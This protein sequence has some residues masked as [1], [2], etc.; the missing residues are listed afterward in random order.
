MNVKTLELFIRFKRLDA[1]TPLTDCDNDEIAIMDKFGQFQVASDG[2]WVAP[3][4]VH[5]FRASIHDLHV[6]NDHNGEY[7]KACDKCRALPQ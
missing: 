7:V 4:N 1:N 6:A 3:K 2:R 5:I